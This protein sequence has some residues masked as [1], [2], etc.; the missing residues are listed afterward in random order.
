[1]IGFPSNDFGAQEPGSNKEVAEFCQLNY[2]VSF[3][4]FEKARC[5]G[6]RRIRFMPRSRNAAAAAPRW[7][8][9]KY[10]IDRGCKPRG[11]F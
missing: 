3:P 7:N 4:M 8:F 6:R 10:L 11:E 2:G 1:M 5:R 9:H